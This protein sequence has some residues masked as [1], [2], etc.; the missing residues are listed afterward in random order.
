M[1]DKIPVTLSEDI[2]T[3]LCFDK[4]TLPLLVSNIQPELFDS[5]YMRNVAV[6]AIN[7]YNEYKEPIGAHL[8]NEFENELSNDDEGN[9]YNKIINGVVRTK[10]SI[11][12][13][14]VINKLSAFIRRQQLKLKVIKASKLLMENKVE[15]ADALIAET[16]SAQLTLFDP[17]TFFGKDN[18]TYSYFDIE[19]SDRGIY[20][21]IEVLDRLGIIPYPK[22]LYMMMGRAGAGKSW[23][24]IHL[25]KMALRQRKKVLHITLELSEDRLK[26]RYFQSLFGIATK[27]E[28]LQERNAIFKKDPFGSLMKI[29]FEDI[30]KN[31]IKLLT[32]K[33]I[34]GFVRNKM[35]RIPPTL[36][37]K[38][39]PTGY[40]TFEELTAFIENLK[41]YY[42]FKPDLL[43]IDYLDLMKVSLDNMRLD[44]GWLGIQLRG[45]GIA[46]DMAVVTV[47]QTNS[48]AEGKKWITRLNI[49]EDYSKIRYADNFLTHN[50]TEVEEMYGLARLFVDKARNEKK[51]SKILIKQNIS[52]GQYCL[53]S[54]LMKESK[55][56]F[57][58]YMKE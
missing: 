47:A 50:Q 53:D 8:L 46:E 12:K 27:K 32:D 34:I 56:Y 41:T 55:E 11:N 38:E 25:A 6:K 1:D 37:I 45:L 18:R 52:L 20:T 58:K 7:F 30:P 13:D 16:K 49:A 35:E 17:G 14:Y 4:E 15:E 33:E 19:D 57:E 22:E 43:L 29:D 39:F 42:N 21:G 9:I 51:G 24:L 31:K 48:G 40:L 44:L 26:G 54:V 5:I 23:M 10:D 36:L 2:L 3:L 28:S